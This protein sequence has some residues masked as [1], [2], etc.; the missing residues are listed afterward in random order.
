ML[1]LANYRESYTLNGLCY[2]MRQ[3]VTCSRRCLKSLSTIRVTIKLECGR[4]FYS[5]ILYNSRSSVRQTITGTVHAPCTRWGTMPCYTER[6]TSRCLARS[7]QSILVD[8]TCMPALHMLAQTMRAIHSS[9]Q[10]F[11]TSFQA[12]RIAAHRFFHCLITIWIMQEKRF[13][14]KMLENILPRLLRTE[15]LP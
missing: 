13:S 7:L 12:W 11:S 8:A 10:T 5:G 3:T 2:F 14:G 1:K 4:D 9:T 6:R 15:F